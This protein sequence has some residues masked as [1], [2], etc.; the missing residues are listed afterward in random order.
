MNGKIFGLT[1]VILLIFSLY[2]ANSIVVFLTRLFNVVFYSSG[3][4]DTIGAGFLVSV[5]YSLLFGLPG[6]FFFVYYNFHDILYKHEKFFLFK[7]FFVCYFLMG[8]G[9]LFGFFVYLFFVFPFLLE[10]NVLFGVVEFFNV[11]VFFH[12]LVFFCL[13]FSI[14]FCT[15]LVIRGLVIFGLLKKEQFK[16]KRLFIYAGVLFVSAF[17][18]PPDVFSMF[19]L[20]V[21]LIG[22]MELGLFFS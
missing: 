9:F 6:I 20:G 21:P 18:S 11:F 16:G 17:V 1:Y 19:L 14:V 7:Y 12:S 10:L 22:L 15:P 4:H 5:S 8:I 3:I 2:Y 13:V